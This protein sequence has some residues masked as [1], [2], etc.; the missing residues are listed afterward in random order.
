MQPNTSTNTTT[1]SAKPKPPTVPTALALAPNSLSRRRFL[2][3]C[4]ALAAAACAG[5]TF[6]CTPAT[7]ESQEGT[8]SRVG[9]TSPYNWEG[10]VR[11]DGRWDYTENGQLRSRWGIDVSEHQ[12]AIDWGQVSAAGVE[13]AFV[14][15]GYRGATEGALAMDEYFLSNATG[16]SAA[17]IQT[18]SYFFS[19]A[20]NEQEAEEEA[21]LAI[22]QAQEAN[23]AGARISI[24]AYDHEPVE[25]NG[26]RANAIGG[27]QLS[28]N[29]IAFC[30]KVTD[31]GFAPLLYGNKR[32]LYRL[33]EEALATYPV[34][35]AEYNTPTPTTLLNFIM[36][37]YS[38]TG[39]VAGISTDVDLN[40]WFD[41][42]AES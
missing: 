42:P 36:W 12:K 38:C 41:E 34:W 8:A 10:L 18:E 35:L 16:A 5:I 25:T 33:S 28:R 3:G 15:I 19:Q 37:Q 27:D 9:F 32:T 6:G 23:K 39:T 7:P 17:G 22:Q 20:I 26:A 24:I 14:R 30:R 13:F 31:A 2:A 21:A 1:A 29:A 40:I 11:T 4:L